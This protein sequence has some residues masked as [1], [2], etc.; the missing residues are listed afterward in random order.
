[1]ML[2]KPELHLD[3][4]QRILS[5]CFPSLANRLGRKVI[6]QVCENALRGEVNMSQPSVSSDDHQS[7]YFETVKSALQMASAVIAI[8][9]FVVTR[10]AQRASP[11]TQQ[12]IQPVRTELSL[13]SKITDAEIA[14][15]VKECQTVKL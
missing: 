14:L 2:N 13:P 5:I 7:T 4:L 11:N 6:A 3:E 15:I 10:K 9:N 8:Y 12:V 1:M